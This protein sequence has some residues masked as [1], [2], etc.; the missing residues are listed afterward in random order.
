MFT[1][2]DGDIYVSELT[3]AELEKKLAEDYFGAQPRMLTKLPDFQ[4]WP[5]GGVLVIRG[6]VAPP[7]SAEVTT[8]WKAGD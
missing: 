7:V 5:E 8:K 3:G 4:Q 2:G 1:G 6:H